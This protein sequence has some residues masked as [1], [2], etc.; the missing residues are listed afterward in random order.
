M[1]ATMRFRLSVLLTFAALTACRT[2]PPRSFVWPVA[3]GWRH[4]TIPFPLDFA[5]DLPFTGVE[6]LRFAPGMFKPEQPDFWTYAF[7]WWLDGH[8]ELGT[9]ELE[10]SLK[11]YFEGLITAV[12][13]D[14]GYPI[15]PARFAATIQAS[16]GHPIKSGHPVSEYTGTVATYDAFATGEPIVL[17]LEIRVWDCPAAGK[18]VAMVLASPKPVTDPIWETLHRRRDE[19]LC[20]GR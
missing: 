14:K 11:R 6:E 17:V 15:D 4:E 18:R 16:H 20:H 3:E 2:A 1:L 19:F 10:R 8:P 9:K 13:K 12:A 5:K 7:A